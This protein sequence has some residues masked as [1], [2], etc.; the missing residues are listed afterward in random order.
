MRESDS[1]EINVLPLRPWGGNG[2]L[3]WVGGV[4]VVSGRKRACHFQTFN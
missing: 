4:T 2:G 3:G 1:G